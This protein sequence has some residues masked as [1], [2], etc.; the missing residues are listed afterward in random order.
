MLMLSYPAHFSGVTLVGI[1]LGAQVVKSCLE[2]LHQFGAHDI[3]YEVY[4]LGG[5]VSFK[6]NEYLLFSS[7]M[8]KVTHVYTE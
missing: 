6:T 1:S 7:V 3:I 8:H 4:F 5:A 2:E